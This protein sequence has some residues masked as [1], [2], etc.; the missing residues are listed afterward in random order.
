M[1]RHRPR[2]RR[3]VPSARAGR[4][5][6]SVRSDRRPPSPSLRH[7][8]KRIPALDRPSHRAA[9]SATAVAQI[10][11]QRR[12]GAE[13]RPACI[14]PS[15]PATQRV[16]R[17]KLVRFRV[18]RVPIEEKQPERERHVADACDDERFARGVSRFPDRRGKSDQQVAARRPT[19]SQ[20]KYSTS[21]LSPSTRINIAN[22]NRFMYAK[23]AVTVSPAM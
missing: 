19:P 13:T 17:A 18:C 7:G 1:W 10:Y 6:A 14:P 8:S 20:P 21:R 2:P 4:D 16:H 12:R 3:V 22:T 15:R 11:Q 23:T 5:R 9:T